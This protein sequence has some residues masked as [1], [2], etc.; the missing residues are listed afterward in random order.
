MFTAEQ[1]QK[2]WDANPA[3]LE[4]A[5]QS[6]PTAFGL[7]GTGMMT[8]DVNTGVPNLGQRVGT[9]VPASPLDLLYQ[10]NQS[11]NAANLPP[12]GF[13]PPDMSAIP[14]VGLFGSTP[15]QTF[16]EYL[17]QGTATQQQ[18]R[19]DTFDLGGTTQIR[20]DGTIVSTPGNLPLE[21]N[22]EVKQAINTAEQNYIN[23]MQA[24]INGSGP[25]P[26]PLNTLSILEE[27]G[28][29]A[30]IEGDRGETLKLNPVTGQ[31]EGPRRPEDSTFATL[32]KQTPAIMGGFTGLPIASALGSGLTTATQG[33]DLEDIARSALTSGALVGLGNYLAPTPATSTVGA[34][35]LSNVV[36][37]TASGAAAQA[38]PNLAQQASGFF[39]K[40]TGL[41]R[42][43]NPA[44]SFTRGSLTSAVGQAIIN[45]EISLEDALRAGLIQTG[46]DTA[47]DVFG[48]IRQTN[49][50]NLIEGVDTTNGVP[51][52]A[53]DVAR[54]TDT[55]DVYTM[56]GPEGIL[57]KVTGLDVPYLPTD[58]AGD[59]FDFI[60]NIVGTNLGGRPIVD[61]GGRFEQE[62]R[63]TVN[64]QV[65]ST[66][67]EN[68][69]NIEL[70]ES[71]QI[72]LNDVLQRNSDNLEFSREM[73]Q[74][75]ENN[76]L[77]NTA[78]YDERF[79]DVFTP[80]GDSPLTGIWEN[81]PAAARGPVV[82]GPSGSSS[83]SGGGTA[84]DG[85]SVGG[86]PAVTGG[87]VF[88]DVGPDEDVEQ[89]EAIEE[90]E[91][92]EQFEEE[93]EVIEEALPVVETPSGLLAVPTEPTPEPVVTPVPEAETEVEVEPTP[94]EPVEQPVEPP[95]EVAPVQEEVTEVPEPET[96]EVVEV[97]EVETP[98]VTEP[99]PE[100]IEEIVE[101]DILEDSLSDLLDDGLIEDLPGIEPEVEPE[102]EIEPEPEPEPELPEAPEVEEVLEE[103]PE[104]IEEVLEEAQEV[105]DLPTEV[106]EVIPDVLEVEPET[107]VEAEDI[108]EELIKEADVTPEVDEEAPE[109]TTEPDVVP[110]EPPVEPPI[111]P[112]TEPPTE[113]PLGLPGIDGVDG[114][115]G[116]PGV[117]GKDGL[118]G[119][120]GIDGK[121][122]LPGVDGAPGVD[123][124]DGEDG[125]DGKDG[126]MGGDEF[127]K[128]M[129]SIDYVAPILREL[130]I[131]LTDYISMWIQGNKA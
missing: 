68:Q 37:N 13:V 107:I 29:P 71:G 102:I 91:E 2:Y 80:R 69:K 6:N 52:T 67:T 64:T 87:G 114:L 79:F 97:P 36:T 116:L 70:Y 41:L 86:L 27:V 47:V 54:L 40:A 103:V 43:Q 108:I 73:M 110:E 123:G 35:G 127:K 76:F 1:L 22:E 109:V 106:P 124:E 59:A 104:T 82:T 38:A 45:G 15:G 95:T 125:E 99:V 129:A 58:W 92:E 60:D 42:S 26:A 18:T 20:P 120:P 19:T 74:Y 81:N 23:Q 44:G 96:P 75:A 112:P 17:N 33:G 31:Y 121:D 113:P 11:Y 62:Y 89:A 34:D 122:G 8:Q 24:F 98:E 7:T 14:F 49:T 39:D 85:T 93:A 84:P 61:P 119:L 66:L 65:E 115:P 3:A 48:D 128:F 25:A 57:S 12:A 50:G 21:V 131:P 46:V 105:T 130:N 4:Q 101:E 72:S 56:L 83:R 78:R 51:M 28:F 126:M 5:I 16:D 9:T 118:P 10:Q 55:S 100:Q 30:E 111:E 53:E 94:V 32:V 88:I 63:D 117:D 90:Q 77:R